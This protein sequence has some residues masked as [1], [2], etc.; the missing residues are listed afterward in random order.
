M[1]RIPRAAVERGASAAEKTCVILYAVASWLRQ[2]EL[3][4]DTAALPKPR[5]KAK[6]REEWRIA[7]G[8]RVEVRR[9]RHTVDEVAAIPGISRDESGTDR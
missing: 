7:T 3:I 2:E 8:R 1:L 5:W 4:P 6:L 9:P